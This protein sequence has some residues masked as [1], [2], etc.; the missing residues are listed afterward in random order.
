MLNDFLIDRT[1][2]KNG[3]LSPNRSLIPCD[4]NP[5]LS[6]TKSSKVRCVWASLDGFDGCVPIHS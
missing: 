6:C 2:N 5:L 4:I 3:S 1:L